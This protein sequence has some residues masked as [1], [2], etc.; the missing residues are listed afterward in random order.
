MSH[1]LGKRRENT[2][3]TPSSGFHRSHLAIKIAK[4]RSAP[5]FS[6]TLSWLLGERYKEEWTMV[7]AHRLILVAE[8]TDVSPTPCNIT[9]IENRSLPVL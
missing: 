1:E 5:A 2:Q 4:T 8:K 7:P 9:V 3:F 6:K